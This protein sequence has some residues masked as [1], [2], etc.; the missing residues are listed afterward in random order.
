MAK[1]LGGSVLAIAF[2]AL[3]GLI[4]PQSGTAR[5]EAVV[6]VKVHSPALEGNK[7][8]DPADQE[9]LIYLPPSYASATERR[10]PT[11]YLLHGYTGAPEGWTEGMKLP[12]IM[13]RA[14]AS[15]TAHEMIVVMPN[16]RNK[17]LG[18][19]YTNSVVTGNWE[20]YIVH[21]VVN[22]VDSHY[23]TLASSASRGIA[24]HSMGGYGAIMLAMK[25]PDVFGAIYALSPC[26]VGMKADLT[27]S[28]PA[29]P[30]AIAAQKS[31][32]FFPTPH[33]AEQFFTDAFTAQGAAW[34]PNPE[35]APLYG[36]LPYR[37]EGGKLVADEPVLKQWED[38]TP[39]A[40]AP[41]YK[42][43]LLQ[44]RAIYIDYGLEDQ[45]SHIR[46]STRLFSDELAE[47]GVPHVLATYT[48]DH[49]DHIRERFETSVVPF[50]SQVLQGK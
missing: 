20:D 47:M 16:G 7:L 49:T 5:G 43:N 32:E 4:L 18:S 3:A 36:E 28:N 26:C 29:W 46:I 21:D 42:N 13:D 22:Y 39:L 48:G 31:G 33:G 23:R 11:L 6:S 19:M 12:E 40:A 9:V 37:E 2:L 30:A 1:A 8:G 15:G 27:S 38:H 10:F 50:F 45:F 44:L 35:H 14:I 24:G 41:N 17:Y 34:A 25:H